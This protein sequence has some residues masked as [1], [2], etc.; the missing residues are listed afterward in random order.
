[1]LIPLTQCTSLTIRVCVIKADVRADHV[2]AR[3]FPIEEGLQN[4]HFATGYPTW[5]GQVLQADQ[6]WDI[7]EGLLANDLAHYTHVL[8]GFFLINFFFTNR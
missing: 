3:C 8:T 5:R 4:A 7:F 2:N 1:M 6:M